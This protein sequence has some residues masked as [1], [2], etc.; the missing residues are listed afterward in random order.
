MQARRQCTDIF[1]VIK[2]KTV[3]P[4]YLQ[5]RLFPVLSQVRKTLKAFSIFVALKKYSSILL[6]CF[7][8]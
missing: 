5:P 3:N 1:K 4:E 7:V 2:E 8:I 6:D